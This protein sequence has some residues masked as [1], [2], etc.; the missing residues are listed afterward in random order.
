MGI[1]TAAI[2]FG[3][4]APYAWPA[5]LAAIIVYILHHGLTKGALFLGVGII[6]DC[7]ARMRKWVWVGCWLPALALAGA[8]FTSGMLAKSLLKIQTLQAPASWLMLWEI[9]LPTSAITTALL[10]QRFLL[11]TA[12][13][14]TAQSVKQGAP[15]N[16]L[17]P[18]G[19]LLTSIAALP[20]VTHW[21]TPFDWSWGRLLDSLW[22]I[23]AASAIL[24]FLSRP[25]LCQRRLNKMLAAS[26]LP[27][28]DILVVY[29]RIIKAVLHG[30]Q[31]LSDHYP[32]RMQE[33]FWRQCQ[34]IIAFL[35]R[36]V[37]SEKLEILL[38]RWPL[39]VTGF[40]LID[41]IL[42]STKLP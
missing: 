2:G 23:L 1:L 3:L 12:P 41:L 22:P 40:I 42:V 20:L 29:E 39:A 5:T 11:L 15:A 33:Y 37:M 34:V 8:P 30:A 19:I 36:K 26:Q 4:M 24:Y 38:A 35:D 25:T 10:L 32:P 13:F 27:P 18:W 17:W 14:K 7:H 28:G 21:I 6:H 31:H 16:G 9:L